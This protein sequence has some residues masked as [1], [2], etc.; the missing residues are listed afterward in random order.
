[1]GTKMAAIGK[2]IAP[3]TDWDAHEIMFTDVEVER[4]ADME[5]ERWVRHHRRDDSRLGPTDNEAKTS[6]Y[7]LPWGGLSERRSRNSIGRPPAHSRLPGAG[8][9]PDRRLGGG[10][11]MKPWVVTMRQAGVGQYAPGRGSGF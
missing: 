9:L 7:L 4:L 5:Y 10:C 11:L 1:M 2:A 3:L 6:P 8:R